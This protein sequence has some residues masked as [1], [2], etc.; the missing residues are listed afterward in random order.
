VIGRRVI[1]VALAAAAAPASADDGAAATALAEITDVQQLSLADL[2]DTQVNIASNKPQTTRETPGI[3][4]VITRDDIIHSGAREL[5]DVLTLVPGFAPGVDVQSVV[6]LGVR[7]QWGHEG[8]ILLLIDG[9]PM[10]ELLYSSLQLANHYP[11]ESV[12]H[13]EVIRGPGSV[14]YGGYAELAVINI[15]TRDAA[16]LEGV[17][18]ATSYGQLGHTVGHANAS[19]S[20][21]TTATGIPELSVV[22]S[23]MLGYANTRGT[24]RDFAGA[25]YALDGHAGADPVFA[26]LAVR[27]RRLRVDAIVDEYALHSRDGYGDV[28]PETS[29]AAFRTIG[30]DARYEIALPAHLTLTPR[31]SVLR[32]SPWEVTDQASAVF[33]DKTTTRTT[34]GVT[35]SYDPSPRIDV[36][37]GAELYF[38]RAHVDALRPGLMQLFNGKTSVAYDT[39]ATYVQ[40]L[41]NHEIANLT[42]GARYEHQGTVG[43]SLV[44]RIALTK[45]VGRFHAKLLASQ[46]FRAPSI[47]NINVSNGTLA[48]EKTT[49][50][51]AEAG[52]ELGRHMFL[53]ANAFDI[54]IKKPIIYGYDQATA[55]E[56]YQNFRRTGTRGLELDYRIQASRVSAHLTYSYYTAAGKNDVDA[57]RVPGHDDVLLAFPAHK[58]TF[59]GS[60]DLTHGLSFNPSAVIYGERFG[61]TASDAEG[62]PVIGRQPPAAQVNLYLL[63]RDAVVPG[64]ELGAGVFDVADQHQPYLQPYNG[65]HAPLPSPGR[66]LVF[67]IAYERKL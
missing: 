44:P 54:T 61:Y 12:D 51:E 7:G 36:L 17:A 45:V 38:D 52:Y 35:L 40:L 60:L 65:G 59:A 66:E 1:L 20:F 64:L 15:V 42:I 55:S 10:N 2:L 34:P 9:Q 30:V 24:Y 31:L 6:D 29:S 67:R 27:F 58:L 43:G 16:S 25:S 47:E 28:N 63:Y 46:A 56:F 37:A 3:V 19:L 8:K 11:L 26:K 5:L 32:Q 13:I 41:V 39:I 14:I 4:T 50:F 48:P 22:G 53:A 33:Y 49:V 23:I 18:V 62:N 21:G 57:Y